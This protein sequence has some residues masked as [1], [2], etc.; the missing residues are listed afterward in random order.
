VAGLWGDGR[1][2]SAMA[3]SPNYVKDETLWVNVVGLGIFKSTDGGQL[4]RPSSAGLE[5]MRLKELLVSP[6]F[7]PR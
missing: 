6:G 5:N 4:W 7:S 2:L 3:A 1:R